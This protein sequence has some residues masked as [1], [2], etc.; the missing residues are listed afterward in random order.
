MFNSIAPPKTPGAAAAA[1]RQILTPPPGFAGE[2][3]WDICH[4]LLQQG[5]GVAGAPAPKFAE[6]NLQQQ[7]ITGRNA[8]LGMTL[9]QSCDKADS[10]STDFPSLGNPYWFHDSEHSQFDAAIAAI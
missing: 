3:A 1:T 7:W 9:A 6:P 8:D 4:S 2:N 10:Q 5:F